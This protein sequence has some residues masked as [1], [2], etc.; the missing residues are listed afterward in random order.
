MLAPRL[1]TTIAAAPCSA[2]SVP[3]VFTSALTGSA[4][5]RQDRL[6][7]NRLHIGL[8]HQPHRPAGVVVGA[9]VRIGEVLLLEQDLR[10]AAVGLIALD[11]V[12]AGGEGPV[13]ELELGPRATDFDSLNAQQIDQQGHTRRVLLS[14]GNHERVRRSFLPSS[15]EFRLLA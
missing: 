7:G 8:K 11:D 14:G 4:A 6:V 9:E 1:G 3:A 15:T 2:V 13:G 10:Q 5:A 12:R